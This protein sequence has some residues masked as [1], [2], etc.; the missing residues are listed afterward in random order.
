MSKSKRLDALRSNP[1]ADW[2]IADIQAVCAE[3]DL[4][5]DPPK[6]GG[7][8]YKVHHPGSATILTIPFRRP[9]KAVYIRKLIAMIDTLRK[10]D[11]GS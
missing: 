5:C 4:R 2:R 7:S 10:T 8:H 6:G 11:E 3:S 1:R 9:I